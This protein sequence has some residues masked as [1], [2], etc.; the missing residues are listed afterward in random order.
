MELILNAEEHEL[1]LEVL[2]E[3]QK[4]MLREISRSDHHEFRES[5][6][7]NERVL[8]SV[9]ARLHSMPPQ[10]QADRVA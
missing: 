4:V 7:R 1:L 6:R 10:G 2:E 5:L 9:I 8:E 3:R